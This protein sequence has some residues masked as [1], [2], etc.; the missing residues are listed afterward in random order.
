MITTLQ[1]VPPL[2]TTGIVREKKE[3]LM[4]LTHFMPSWEVGVEEPRPITVEHE[5]TTECHHRSAT[6]YSSLIP[7]SSSCGTRRN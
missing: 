6:N 3:A 7:R 1:R 2:Q 5:R 4:T